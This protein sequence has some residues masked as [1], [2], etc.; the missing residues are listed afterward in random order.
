[1]RSGNVHLAY[2][3]GQNFVGVGYFLEEFGSSFVGIF[4]WRHMGKKSDEISKK[5]HQ[6]ELITRMERKGL[7]KKR[8]L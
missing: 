8:W 1:M 2:R 3:I 4:V 5:K 6:I 7:E